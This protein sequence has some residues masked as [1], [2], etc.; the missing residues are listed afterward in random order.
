[1]FWNKASAERCLREAGSLVIIAL[2]FDKLADC[3]NASQIAAKEVPRS[4]LVLA[5]IDGTASTTTTGPERPIKKQC[6]SSLMPGR[7]KPSAKFVP[8]IAA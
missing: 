2:L 3:T 7:Y 8:G 1:M 4:P 5:G 6:I